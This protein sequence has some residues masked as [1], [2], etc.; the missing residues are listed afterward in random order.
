HNASLHPQKLRSSSWALTTHHLYRLSSLRRFYSVSILVSKSL[1]G[2]KRKSRFYCPF[3][4]FIVGF[5]EFI[6]QNVSAC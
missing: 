1:R 5:G 6:V 3:F 2:L 4:I